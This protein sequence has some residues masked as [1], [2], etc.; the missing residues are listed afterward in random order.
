MNYKTLRVLLV[1]VIALM[2]AVT[3]IAVIS[4]NAVG[5]Q[6]IKSKQLNED[7][8]ETYSLYSSIDDEVDITFSVTEGGQVDIYIMSSDE[9][10]KYNRDEDF[11][12]S[13]TKE[14]KSRLD[15]EKWVQPDDQDYYL[16]I[17]NKNNA[18]S[19]DAE[20]D[21]S[22]T[23]DLE[24]DDHWAEDVG[25]AIATVCI[26]CGA[27]I[28][29]VVIV[30]IYLI[31][32][33]KKADTVI[34][35]PSVMYPSPSPQYPPPQIP[36]G[37]SQQPQPPATPTEPPKQYVMPI[38]RRPTCPHCGNNIETNWTSCPFCAKPLN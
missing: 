4:M 10:S 13:Y 26:A 17:D 38:A 16:V 30:V 21:G 7:E 23:Y 15:N 22:I 32:R 3:V 24:Y 2:I 1:Y 5:K 33:K 8:H 19:N 37:Y 12:A 36:F 27:I 29:V 25:E 34:V 9:Y 31:V 14:K 6:T 18:H 11:S 28:V 35:Q 20:P